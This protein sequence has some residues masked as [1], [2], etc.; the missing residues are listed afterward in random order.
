M[1]APFDFEIH[2]HRAD[3]T[4]AVML[5]AT[6]T[7]DADAAAQARAMLHAGLSHAHIWRDGKLNGTVYAAD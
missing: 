7:D 5:R 6:A 1:T 2:L 3:G 4:M